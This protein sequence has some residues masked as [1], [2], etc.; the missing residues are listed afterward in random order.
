MYKRKASLLVDVKKETND[1]TETVTKPLGF[2][3][4]VAALK[5]ANSETN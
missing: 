4:K 5:D 1:A 3:H 2:R